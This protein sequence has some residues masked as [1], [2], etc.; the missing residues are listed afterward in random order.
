M[1]LIDAV[2]ARTDEITLRLEI[3]LRGK[4]RRSILD[5]DDRG[6]T[7]EETDRED[8]VDPLIQ[9]VGLRPLKNAF[10]FPIDF[11]DLAVFID[12]NEVVHDEPPLGVMRRLVIGR[13][14]HGLH[15]RPD[16]IIGMTWKWMV[17]SAAGKH[18]PQYTDEQSMHHR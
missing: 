18:Q 15:G 2:A 6:I 7:I 9:R 13:L 16:L 1:A 17:R 12:I 8:P 3:E 4:T 5:L 11:D 14:G 10:Q